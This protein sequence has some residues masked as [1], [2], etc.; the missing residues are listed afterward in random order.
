MNQEKEKENA[1]LA[2][3]ELVF[4]NFRNE[5]KKIKLYHNNLLPQARQA[6]EVVLSAYKT[7]N[8]D[9][10]NFIDSQRTYLDLE[11]KYEHYLSVYAQRQAELEM[12][13]GKVLF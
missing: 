13:V 7:G 6:V 2:K 9:I 10:L 5:E 3:L 11:L 4:Y 1:L 12:L 8:T